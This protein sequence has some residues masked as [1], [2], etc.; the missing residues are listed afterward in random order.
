MWIQK[1]NE[2]RFKLKRDI[3][4]LE[5]EK[6]RLTLISQKLDLELEVKTLNDNV[7][8]KRKQLG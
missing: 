2:N 1:L 5:S 7:E 4:R 8:E 6:E 3:K